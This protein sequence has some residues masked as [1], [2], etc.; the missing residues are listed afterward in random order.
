MTVCDHFFDGSKENYSL[1]EKA[2]KSF[3]H[4][5]FLEFG[6]D[7]R[8]T[9]RPFSPFF[10]EH[11]NWRHEW[12]NT[13]RWLGFLYALEQADHLFFLDCDEIVEEKSFVSWLNNTDLTSYSAYRFA[14][15]WHFREARFVAEAQDDLCLLV[16]KS[17]LVPDMLWDEDERCGL[18]QRVTGNKKLNVK[19]LGNIPMIRHYS[20]VRTIGEMRKK[21]ATWGHHWERNWEVLIEEEFSRSFNGKDFIRGYCYN[22]VDPDFDPLLEN[23]P[24][25]KEVSL[26]EHVRRLPEFPNVKRISKEEAFKK[27][28]NLILSHEH[29]HGH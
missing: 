26:E 19:G 4:C 12:H 23:V 18:F 7:P 5:T 9:F 24:S 27:E 16:R 3:P 11:V 15:F 22:E 25:L 21:M 13:G 10:P 6:F 2:F 14:G 1:L 8:S 28:L 29:Q 20:G 17:A